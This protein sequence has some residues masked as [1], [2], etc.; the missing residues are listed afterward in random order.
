MI[1]SSL[2]VADEADAAADPGADEDAGGW[3]SSSELPD[4]PGRLEELMVL[5]LARPTPMREPAL[6][7]SAL[8]SLLYVVFISISSS[9][10]SLTNEG[11]L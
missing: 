6:A 2:F 11:S 9:L 3:D 4:L 8:A 1:L 10:A 7:R 5:S